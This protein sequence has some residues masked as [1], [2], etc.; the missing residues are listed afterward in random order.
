MSVSNQISQASADRG[1]AD[2]EAVIRQV[3]APQSRKR[4]QQG[5]QACQRCRIRKVKCDEAR[6]R[7]GSCRKRHFECAYELPAGQTRTQALIQSQQDLREQMRSNVSFIYAL[8]CVGSN[9]A[10]QMLCRLR[11]GDYDESLLG[12]RS[13]FG[14]GT[15]PTSEG[16][17][18]DDAANGHGG[19]NGLL[20]PDL[21][22][23]SGVPTFYNMRSDRS[24]RSDRAHLACLHPDHDRSTGQYRVAHAY[25]TPL[26][27]YPPRMSLDKVLT[28]SGQ[29]SSSDQSTPTH[30]RLETCG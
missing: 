6:P 26:T 30:Q 21:E 27:S 10:T 14:Q 18:W 12:E 7:C 4:R 8:R 11:K 29:G 20:D 16:F 15:A 5:T 13:T 19:Y 23:A 1:H 3:P 28:K 2:P 22:T 24:A 17:P 25:T 9:E